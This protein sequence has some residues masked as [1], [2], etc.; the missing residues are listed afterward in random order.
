MTA[1]VLKFLMVVLVIFPLNEA[2]AQR[3]IDRLKA[4]KSTPAQSTQ[5][6]V[7]NVVGMSQSDAENAI[8]KAGLK[9]GNIVE[10]ETQYPNGQVIKQKPEAD[11]KA[12][13]GSMVG[14]VVSKNVG[15]AQ[16]TTPMKTTPSGGTKQTT[17]PQQ[18]PEIVVPNVVGM[19]QSD[20]ETTIT[21]AGLR[22]AKIVERE[23]KYPTGQVVKQQPEAGA[24]AAQGTAVVLV[25]SQ[26]AGAGQTT[27]MPSTGSKQTGVTLK[28]EWFSGM[29]KT[30]APSIRATGIT[31]QVKMSQSEQPR[32]TILSLSTTNRTLAPGE[33]LLKEEPVIIEV[34]GGPAGGVHPDEEPD[35][36]VGL[37]PSALVYK[38]SP[39]IMTGIRAQS[40]TI[41]TQPLKM[42]GI[43][44]QS[45]T[46]TTQ[47][48][49]MTGMRA[50]SQTITTQP[51]KM[52]GMRAQSQTITTQ[53]L[54]MTGMR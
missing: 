40:Q 17:V 46:I 7:P 34:S 42:T 51:L 18:N 3:L 29:A 8:T 36:T 28:T 50:Q 41:T 53:P 35:Q 39:L 4:K 20:A 31:V 22:I 15:A 43:R 49:K 33:V 10:R 54:K 5:V 24:K 38:T 12:A 52:T 11:T 32:G 25:V 30:V 23:T 2:S 13:P 9:L 1:K 14:M 26:N 37:L 27:T 47:P 21:N 19:N 45:Q 48:L 44:A 16:T 6:T